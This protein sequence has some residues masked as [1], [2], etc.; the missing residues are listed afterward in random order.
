MYI[1][2][3]NGVAERYS[4]RQLRKDNPQ[5]SFPEKPTLDTLAALGIYPVTNAEMP[6]A[7]ESQIVERDV[8]PTDQGDGTYVW[9]WTVRDK[10]LEEKRA[11]MVCTRQ[12]GKLALGPTV[13]ASVLALAEDLTTPWGLKVAIED[14]VE[15]E[16]MDEDMAALIW[17]MQLT[18]EQAD[19]LFRLAMTL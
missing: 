18:E 2:I 7:T 5:T 17:A 13:W 3:T 6:A 11:S 10:T 4:F 12:Q 19:D 16:R 8:Q 15:W 14:T 1:K 9:G